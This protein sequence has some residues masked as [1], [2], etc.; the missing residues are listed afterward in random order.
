MY[1][2]GYHIGSVYK[3]IGRPDILLKLSILSVIILVPSL[4]VGSRFGIV[5]IGW[6][7]LFAIIFRRIIS[8]NMAIRFIHVTLWDIVRELKPAML[9]A[10]PMAIVTLLAL[11]L[12]TQMNPFIRLAI[13]VLSGAASYLLALWWFEKENLFQLARLLLQR[14]KGG[15]KGDLEE[16]AV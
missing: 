6:G 13:V 14:G 3:A 9:G 4:L 5:G 11:Y 7:L 8:I 2:I 10:L 15:R 16:I 1:S 12:T